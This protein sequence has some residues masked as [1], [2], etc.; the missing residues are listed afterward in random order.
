VIGFSSSGY[1]TSADRLGTVVRWNVGLSAS[2]RDADARIDVTLRNI[3]VDGVARQFSYSIQ[4]IR[5]QAPIYP[6]MTGSRSAAAVTVAWAAAVERGVPVTGY[7]VVGHDAGGV[8]FDQ[9]TG[10]DVRQA[11]LPYAAPDRSVSVIVHPISR[12]Q[13]D[14]RGALVLA[15]PAPALVPR[16]PLTFPV[17]ALPPP[18]SAPRP[19]TVATRARFV[20]PVTLRLV[21]PG[22]TRVGARL[23]VRADVRSEKRLRYQ[24]R[25][26]GRAIARATRSTYLVRRADRG[27]SISVRLTAVGSDAVAVRRTSAARRI[28]AR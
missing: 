25:R 7:R 15:P 2:D 8:A 10:V 4:A 14:L 18:S 24:W 22:R 16:P 12:L 26:S 13:G 6:A 28:P 5:A 9:V 20:G 3:K 17:A 11:T 27:R 21:R 23:A 19:S 1:A